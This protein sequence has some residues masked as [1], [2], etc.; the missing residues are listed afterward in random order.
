MPKV[1]VIIPL[2]NKQAEIA[3]AIG[4]VLAQTHTDVT[5]LV[6]DDASTDGSAGIV[7]QMGDPRVVLSR[8]EH[9]GAASA[10]NRGI[11]EARTDL[12]A[13]LDADDEWKPG[14]LETTLAL[15]ER[16]P[17]AGL[18]AT[19]FEEVSED[20]RRRERLGFSRVPTRPEGGLIDDF[21]LSMLKFP[22]VCSS[23]VVARKA[24]FEEIGGFPEA[25]VLGEDWDTWAR[26]ALRYKIGFSPAVEMI[27]HADASNRAEKAQR[28]HGVETTLTR[29]LRAALAENRFMT[30]KRRSVELFLGKH[31]LKV[32]QH[33]LEAGNTTRAREL[34]CE[35]GALHAFPAK[36][37]RLW[38]R[39][40]QSRN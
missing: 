30:T 24:I 18:W 37:C 21:F 1:T 27:Y 36:R 26:V 16:Y 35:A 13:F 11:K 19:A 22:P 5:V 31:L 17:D 7:K 12:I 9:R 3:R 29:T 38:L 10:R 8:Q 28:F 32:A 34:I 33:C 20:G 40:L 25:E 14:F 2:Y 23:N 39:S 15:A 4:S 6:V